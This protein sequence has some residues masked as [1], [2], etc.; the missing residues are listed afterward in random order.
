MTSLAS[1]CDRRTPYSCQLRRDN[2]CVS[3]IDARSVAQGTSAFA[4]VGGKARLVGVVGLGPADKAK[5]VPKWGASPFQVCVRGKSECTFAE[6]SLIS[7]PSARAARTARLQWACEQAAGT[8]IAT[9]AK[10]H[11]AKTAAVTF[12]DLPALSDAD[13]VRPKPPSCVANV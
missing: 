7:P 2:H 3:A 12:V 9:G 11:K 8:A 6:T 1:R 5:V 10:T 13:K 4:R